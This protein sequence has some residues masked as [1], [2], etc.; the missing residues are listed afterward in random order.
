VIQYKSQDN[1]NLSLHVFLP[2]KDESPIKR[3]AIVFFFGGGWTTGEP[4]QF[5]QQSRALADLGMVAFCAEYRIKSKHHT[6]PFESVKD[7]KSAIRWVRAHAAELGIDPDRIVAAGGSAGGHVAACAGLVKGNEEAGEDMKVSSVPN[8]LI[9]FNPVLDTTAKGYG[10]DRFSS[11]DQTT[12]SPCHLVR[13]GIPP[14]LTLHGTADKTVPFENAERFTRLMQEAGNDCLLVPFTGQDH[15]FF[16]GSFFRPKS[17]DVYFN[18][19]MKR[20]VEFLT[21][22]GYLQETPKPGNPQ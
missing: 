7:G 5:Y 20:A 18:L 21:A 11:D 4:K 6:T 9:L 19:T 2:S 17:D 13:Q 15:G 10:A 3:A 14:T 22:H 16:N 8:M 12:L 1:I